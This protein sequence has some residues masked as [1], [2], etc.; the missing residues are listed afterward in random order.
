MPTTDPVVTTP[1]PVEPQPVTTVPAPVVPPVSDPVPSAPAVVEQQL[2]TTPANEY[3]VGEEQA[4]LPVEEAS[5]APAAPSPAPSPPPSKA[6]EAPVVASADVTGPLKA[7]LA[8]V[9]ENNPIVQGLT[10]LVLLLLGTAY[11][12]ALR[13]KGIRRPRLNDK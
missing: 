3:Y 12:R 5:S 8:P 2:P 7:A 1:A 9:A 10:V 11:F 6:A 4:E 13:S